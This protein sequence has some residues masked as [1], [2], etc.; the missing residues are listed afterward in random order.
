MLSRITKEYRNK[1]LN[2]SPYIEELPKMIQIEPT[3]FCNLKCPACSSAFIKEKNKYLT[4]D[5]FIHIAD[6]IP[7]NSTILLYHFGEP[8]LNPDIFDIISEGKKRK[9]RLLLHSNL[10]FEKT[11]IPRIVESG[12]DYLSASI[13]GATEE[14]YS[15]YRL[16][17]DFNLALDNFRELV[18]LRKEKAA[19]HLVIK[20]QVVMNK[21]NMKEKDEFKK[22]LAELP[23][24][25]SYAFIPM[26]FREDNVDWNNLSDEELKDTI[27]YWL[28]E[29]KSKRMYRYRSDNPKALMEPIRCPH[30]WDTLSINV[31]GDVTPCCYTYK[32]EHSFGNVF[33]TPLTHIWN[34][35]MYVSS[36]KHFLDKNYTECNT[37][38][39]KCQ[40]YIR[41]GTGNIFT[42][43]L[44]FIVW[45]SSRL[46]EKYRTIKP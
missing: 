7:H 42:R 43:N 33:E 11:L 5:E 6:Q 17:G 20:F 44:E 18:R 46:K 37:V 14:T 2:V 22:I 1:V 28:P 8:F 38:C 24:K 31:Y 35:E 34:N 15:L 29:D 21:Y 27:E 39:T 40:N 4:T 36:R 9:F 3:N 16:K 30:L 45:L 25:V 26:G 12:L 13:D 41:T 32:K 23:D 19:N 10:N